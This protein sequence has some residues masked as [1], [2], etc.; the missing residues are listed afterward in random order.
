MPPAGADPA[1]L[2]GAPVDQVAQAASDHSLMHLVLQAGPVVQSVMGALVLA[3]I[4]CWTIMIEKGFLLGGLQREIRRLGATSEGDAVNGEGLA[5]R[6]QRAAAREWADGR[7]AGESRAEYRER[8]ERAMRE[9]LTVALRRAQHGTAFLATTGAVGPFVGLFGTVWGIM[10]SFQGIAQSRDTS[11][12]VVAPGIAEAL[13]ATAIGLF[14][15][16]PAVIG[17]NRIARRV[18]GLRAE[19][20]AAISAIGARLSARPPRGGHV[21][22][23]AAE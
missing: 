1:V 6:I 9:T 22:A 20:L 17:Y 12:A 15:A 23:R 14:A 4:V 16:I 5:A 19:G 10:G 21:A 13:L 18:A 11:L 7:D 2:A 8:I 3:S